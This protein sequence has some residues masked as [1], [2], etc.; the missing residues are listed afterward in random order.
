MNGKT[1]LDLVTKG[2]FELFEHH[3]SL[4]PA[5]ECAD[6]LT[7]VLF[8]NT[9]FGYPVAKHVGFKV[10]RTATRTVFNG[11][12]ILKIIDM[13]AQGSLNDTAV[14]DYYYIESKSL[15][16]HGENLFYLLETYCIMPGR[17]QTDSLHLSWA[18]H[19]MPTKREQNSVI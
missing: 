4:K 3:F 16:S 19:T 11:H 14:L 17:Q 18:S 13:K 10:A 12:R 15:R 6:L 2:I 7:K 9:I 8:D 1:H 5:L